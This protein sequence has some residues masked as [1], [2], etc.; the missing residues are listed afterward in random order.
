[1]LGALPWSIGSE[2][3]GVDAQTQVTRASY[4]LMSA[5]ERLDLVAANYRMRSALEAIAGEH[6]G[7]DMECFR[8]LARVALRE[9]ELV[10]EGIA[11]CRRCGD[12]TVTSC[13]CGDAP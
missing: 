9:P 8:C 1:M 7:H 6:D 4:G 5:Q 10:I 13:R 3:P 12:A 2:E 11:Y